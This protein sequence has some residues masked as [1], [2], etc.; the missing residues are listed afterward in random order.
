MSAAAGIFE[1][2][3]LPILEA[4][5]GSWIEKARAVARHLGRNGDAVTVDRVRA[6]LPPPAGIDGRVM[7]GIFI[8]SEWE[9]VGFVNSG[10]RTCHGRP[11]REF[12]LLP[13]QVGS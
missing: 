2:D 7:G 8:R 3:I 6:V 5:H 4:K 13:T 9:A 12:M 10:R 11:V 1:A